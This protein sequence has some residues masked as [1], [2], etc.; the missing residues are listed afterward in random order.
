MPFNRCL[1]VEQ[2]MKRRWKK[3]LWTYEGNWLIGLV[4]K[5]VWDFYIVVLLHILW[6]LLTDRLR[7]YASRPC[8]LC[9]VPSVV[10][11]SSRIGPALFPGRRLYEATK[12]D[13][14]LLWSPYGIGRTII[15][16]PCGFFFFFLLF[17]PRLIS[18]IA[19]WM[20]A[21]L[22]HMVWP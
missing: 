12:P 3:W 18:A 11:K 1:S 10:A 6:L 15:F 20:S 17:F 22:P 7:K 4:I 2:R 21:I 19:D 5:F 16:L 9:S 14:S 8:T 13:F